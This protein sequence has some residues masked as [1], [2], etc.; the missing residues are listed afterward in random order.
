MLWNDWTFSKSKQEIKTEESL[1]KYNKKKEIE[2][3]IQQKR[4]K[5]QSITLFKIKDIFYIEDKYAVYINGYFK[6]KRL[7]SLET[8]IDM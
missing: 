4:N 6:E 3:L 1:N 8:L 5:I 2:N 7:L